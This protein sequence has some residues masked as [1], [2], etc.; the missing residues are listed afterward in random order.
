MENE[1][2]QVCITLAFPASLNHIRWYGWGWGRMVKPNFLTKSELNKLLQLPPSMMTRAR[3]LLMM[4]KVWNKL[5][6]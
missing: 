4:K 6:H 3:R 2:L 1:T 5:W